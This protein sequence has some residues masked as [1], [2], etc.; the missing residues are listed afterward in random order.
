[1]IYLST[2]L[3]SMFITIVLIPVLRNPA[4]NKFFVDM[5]NA[6]KVHTTPIPKTG[7]IAMAIGILVPTLLWTDLD[8]FTRSILLGA[9]VLIFFGLIDDIRE[10]GYRT[11]L[12]GQIIAALIAVL[13]GGISATFLDSI[14]PESRFITV[15]I[16]TPLT[17]FIIIGVTNAINLSD[18]LD[19]LAGGI[20]MLGF[21]CIAYLGFCCDQ[22]SITLISIAVIGAI[23][24][25]LR[26]NTFPAAV[27]MGD[28][29]SQLLG[30]LAITT[31]LYLTQSNTPLSP[32]LPILL[33]GFPILD[34]LT[35]MTERIANG[36]SPFIADKNHFH[37]KLMRLGCYHTEAVFV[38]YLLQAFMVTS[39]FVFRFYSDL[40]LLLY[41]II[42]SGL[43]ITGFVVADRKSWKF[44]RYDL[45]DIAIKGR[46]KQIRGKNYHIRIVFLAVKAGLPMLLIITCFV[47]ASIPSYF[48]TIG[49]VMAIFLFAAAF[50]NKEWLGGMIRLSLFMIIPLLL[51]LA[52]QNSAIWYTPAV[53]TAYN[54]SIGL[55]AALVIF[56]LKFT[57]RKQ[58]FKTTPTDFIILFVALVLPNLPD[59]QIRSYHL[60]MLTTRI[61]V[62]FFSLEVLIG[63]LRKN[64]RGMAIL[65]V[66]ILLILSFRGFTMM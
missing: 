38:I 46:L 1:M 25:F 60:G 37:H 14:L 65:T 28:T 9:F 19:G 49:V 35:V 17:I 44:K 57:R 13:Y 20:T 66:I 11:K 45:I 56:T 62:L 6:R 63:E 3:I 54:L 52:E 21:I 23:F 53:S 10:L 5:P 24:G 31:S 47:P 29:G 41:Y 16:S 58:G 50:S 2:L 7:G 40:F 32:L 15:Y 43:I 34:T 4:F 59:I 61:I 39:A 48:S 8:P 55:M 30:F 36:K 18:G 26:F 12:F 33:L 64:Y 22:H 42:F 51:Y 27:F